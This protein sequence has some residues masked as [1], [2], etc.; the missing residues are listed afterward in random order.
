MKRKTPNRLL[1]KP[2]VIYVDPPQAMALRALSAK[3]RRSLQIY[4]REGL[5]MVLKKYKGDL[6]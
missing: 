4:L 6:K 3:T 5:D 2:F 1:K